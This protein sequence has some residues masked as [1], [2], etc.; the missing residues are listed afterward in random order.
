M[1]LRK[2]AKGVVGMAWPGRRTYSQY[3][4][5]VFIANFFRDEPNGVWLDIGAFHPRYSSNTHKLRR[6]G[7]RGINVDM[8][9]DKV[10]MFNWFRRGDDNFAVA[11][12]GPETSRVMVEQ[13]GSDS[14]GSMDRVSEG[15][16]AGSIQARDIRW[17]LDQ[18]GITKVN[19][20][21]IDV[22]GFEEPILRAF[23]FDTA[24]VDLFCVEILTPSFDAIRNSGVNKVLEGAG[25]QLVGWHPPSVFY[26]RD[27]RPIGG[28]DEPVIR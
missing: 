15:D 13:I 27:P 22:E 23:P 21:S 17:I 4:E 26:S 19:L 28:V 2:M 24:D 3:A 7:W 5:D 25:Y 14:Y 18:A 12:A 16:G 20:V 6:N 11:V 8:D 1:D 10:R 9:A